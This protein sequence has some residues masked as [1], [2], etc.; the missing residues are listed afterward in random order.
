M[1]SYNN[2]SRWRTV[3][4]S[5]AASACRS[6]SRTLIKFH[7]GCLKTAYYGRVTLGILVFVTAPEALW[8]ST[9]P[10]PSGDVL[11]LSSCDIGGWKDACDRGC[12]LMKSRSDIHSNSVW[13]V[14]VRLLW[15]YRCLWNAKGRAKETVLSSSPAEIFT[16]Y[17]YLPYLNCLSE[18]SI[19]LDAI[20][21][22][23][24]YL[25]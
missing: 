5:R 4:G 19:W 9:T 23:L 12:L 20:C 15:C 14:G 10:K 8:A 7:G 22:Y 16:S 2:V 17:L 1:P 18:E 25:P 21:I 11:S 13:K 6:L 24:T 3:D